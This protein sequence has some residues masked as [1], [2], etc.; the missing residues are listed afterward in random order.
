MARDATT[1]AWPCGERERDTVGIIWNWC[2]II[3]YNV[4]VFFSG[5]ICWHSEMGGTCTRHAS[6]SEKFLNVQPPGKQTI[7]CSKVHICIHII[8]ISHNIMVEERE[9]E[10]VGVGLTWMRD[11]L[12]QVALQTLPHVLR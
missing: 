12:P 3:L 4:W 5:R 7:H 8:M 10:S 2:E 1:S 11:R 6:L 9:R